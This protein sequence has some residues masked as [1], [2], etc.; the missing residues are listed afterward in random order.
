M[1][2]CHQWTGDSRKKFDVFFSKLVDGG[3]DKYP[4]PKSFKLAK[5]QVFP[6]KGSCYDYVYDK[7]N[8][9]S[10]IGWVEL[11]KDPPV[12]LNAKVIKN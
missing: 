10:W 9:G 3:D 6:E 1:F 5:N 4:R 11:E 2:L 12:P 8:G 7:K